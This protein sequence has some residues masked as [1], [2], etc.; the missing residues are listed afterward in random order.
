M[1]LVTGASGF[2]GRRLVPALIEKGQEV[3]CLSRSERVDETG[4]EWVSGDLLQP[5]TIDA[6]LAGVDTAYYLVHSLDRRDFGQVDRE[7]ARNFVSAADHCGVRRVIY[8]SGLGEE[9]SLSP[10]LDSRR[11]VAQILNRGRYDLTE[12][13]AAIILGA[14]GASYEIIR[15]LVKTQP[16]LLAPRWLRARIQPIAV[17]NVIGYLLGCLFEETTAGEGFDIGG[18]EILTY[19]DL[20]NRF[21]A[22]AGEVNLMLP[23]PVF[24]ARLVAAMVAVATPVSYAVARSLL[25]GIDSDVICEETRI[26]DYIP[27]TLIPL[28]EAVEKALLEGREKEKKGKTVHGR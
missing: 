3:R 6:A 16:V 19:R 14:G 5:E 12:L 8:L 21:A 15:F 26:R 13:R 27:Q 23:T 4:A 2:I 11:E 25:E 7:A 28:E 9:N 18:P 17:D 1:I 24:S 10:H 20:L 22:V